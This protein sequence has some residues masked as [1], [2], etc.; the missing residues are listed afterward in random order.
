MYPVY[1]AHK[2]TKQ[3]IAKRAAKFLAKAV[4]FTFLAMALTALA[5]IR[6]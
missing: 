5:A 3:L 4:A 6:R 1:R 2:S